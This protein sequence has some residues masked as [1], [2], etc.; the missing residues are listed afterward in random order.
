LPDFVSVQSV[1]EVSPNQLRLT[2]PE[3]RFGPQQLRT[4]AFDVTTGQLA[5]APTGGFMV[6]A[7]LSPDGKFAAGYVYV[8]R[9]PIE[10]DPGSGPLTF[11]NLETGEQTVLTQPA[12]AWHFV[13][14]QP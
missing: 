13:W 6:D 2:L 3:R 7:T 5:A 4:A 10:S 9:E 1:R 12:A 14:A 8:A 11:R